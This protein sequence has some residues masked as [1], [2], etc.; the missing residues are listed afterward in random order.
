MREGRENEAVEKAGVY[1]D[2]RAL[3]QQR[4]DGGGEG[5]GVEL[6][7]RMSVRM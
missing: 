5:L 1:C 3:G 7:G 6:A 4:A 2:D